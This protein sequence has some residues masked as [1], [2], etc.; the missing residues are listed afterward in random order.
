MKYLLL[1]YRDFDKYD[2]DPDIPL[3]TDDKKLVQNEID[4]LIKNGW[5]IISVDLVYGCVVVEDRPDIEY[6]PHINIEP[7]SWISSR[8]G[9]ICEWCNNNCDEWET[10]P[11]GKKQEDLRQEQL[12]EIELKY[13]KEVLKIKE[14]FFNNVFGGVNN[15]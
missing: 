12:K 13:E 4:H 1:D 8:K 2:G 3:T 15:G 14:Q 11:Q 6:V 10:C 9:H 7:D 5:T